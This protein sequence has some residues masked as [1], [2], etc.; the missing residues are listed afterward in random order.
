MSQSQLFTHF[1]L[2]LF[3]TVLHGQIESVYLDERGK[4]DRIII[5]DKQFDMK[6]IPFLSFAMNDQTD[7]I[8]EKEN[9]RIYYNQVSLSID[10]MHS[11]NGYWTCL[12]TL[13]NHSQFDTVTIENVVPFGASRDRYHI[14]GQGNHRLSRSVLFRPSEMDVPVIL[15]DNAWELGFSILDIPTSDIR[16]AAL[17]RRVGCQNCNRRRFET[18]LFPNGTVQYRMYLE[19]FKGIWQEGLRT[20]F[21]K[22]WL[23][24]IDNFNT[25]LYDRKDLEWIRHAYVIH[26]IMAWDHFYT[27]QNGN[28]NR[29]SNFV[30]R[31]K[32]LYG[33]DDV[34]GLWPTWPS[35]GLD[36]RNQFD[37]YHD[38]PGGLS[39]LQEMVNRLHDREVKFFIAYNPWDQSTRKEDHLLGMSKLL[40]E[41]DADGVILDTRGSSSAEFQEAADQSKKGVIMFSEGMAVPKDMPGIISGRVHNALYYPP[42]LNLNRFIKPDFSIFRVAELTYEP[43][44]REFN[45]SLFNGHGVEINMFRPGQP[46]WVE[47]NYQYLGRCA[48]ILRDNS[49]CFSTDYLPLYP[50]LSDSI[51]INSWKSEKKELY[52]LYSYFPEGGNRTA[53]IAPD[54][55]NYHYVDLWHHEEIELNGDTI[56]VQLDAFNQSDLGTNNEGAVSAVAGFSEHLDVQVKLPNLLISAPE[57]F[58]LKV[59]PGVPAYDKQPIEFASGDTILPL[60]YRFPR[61]EGKIVI[62]LFD[63]TELID[64]RIARIIPG[65]PILISEV[66]RT[67]VITSPSEEMVLVEGG[68]YRWLPDPRLGEFIPY[69]EVDS[70]IFKIPAFFMDRHPVTNAEFKIF[71]DQ[72]NY[73]PGDTSNFLK[74]WKKYDFQAIADHP[75]IYISLQ[76][77]KAYANWHGKRLPTEMEWQYAAEGNHLDIWPW[78]NDLDSTKTNLGDGQYYAVGQYKNSANLRGLEDLCGMVWQLTNDVYETGSYRYSILKGGSYFKPTSSWWYVKGG[79]QPPSHRQQ[80]LHVSEG[81]ERNATVGFRCIR[82]IP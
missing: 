40:K 71:L 9:G 19:H 37:L 12:L 62:Q 11:I 70:S 61:W 3:T 76:D 52:T 16:L 32:S 73:V 31:G 33:G 26:L 44:R 36:Q 82:D 43:I 54:P 53:F 7:S 28:N 5:D 6:N 17:T 38:L 66:E 78:G 27:E 13:T 55:S 69:P 35:L 48:R 60:P 63:R 2:L 46:S 67:A 57:G 4:V 23:F 39:G 58:E 72:S 25:D 34:I 51:L 20:L 75:V 21:Q 47:E 56:T 24:D 59:W 45:L 50:S 74:H 1:F 10:S 29:L 49:N 77:A 22:R 79:P 80:L 65:Q 81:F 18:D 30:W 8:G 14:T 15:P 42:I 41:V 68:D 64:E